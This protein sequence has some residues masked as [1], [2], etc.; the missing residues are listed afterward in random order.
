MSP[1]SFQNLVSAV[2]KGTGKAVAIR[3]RAELEPVG[4]ADT[5]VFPPTYTHGDKDEPCYAIN[6]RIVNGEERNVSVVLDSVPSQA[7]RASLAMEDDIHAP[8][9]Y[10]NGKLPLKDILPLVST[11]HEAIGKIYDLTAPHRVSDAIFRDSLYD[12]TLFR[13]S[14]VGRAITQA[15]SRDISA[16]F[17]HS[18][19][20]L[21]FGYWDSSGPL[22]ERGHKQERLYSSEISGLD[23]QFGVTTSSKI[24]P[25]G[26]K[27]LKKKEIYVHQN[28]DEVWTLSPEDARKG[29]GNKSETIGNPSNL[30]HGNIKPAI[31]DTTGGAYI[32][33]AIQTSTLSIQATQ[34]LRFGERNVE[35]EHAAHTV[36]IALGLVAMTYLYEAGYHLRSGCSLVSTGAPYF[37]MIEKDGK[38]KPFS[39]T[40][41]EATGLL[42]EAVQEAEKYGIG[43]DA[44]KDSIRMTMSPKLVELV[45]L[46]REEDSLPEDES[47][48]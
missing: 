29:K 21:L 45:Q 18:P 1:L 4:G 13:I 14:D 5:K 17:K 24:D 23:P 42:Q 38:T 31:N 11:E 9:L 40:A 47:R 33:K 37:E 46:S 3:F 8:Q 7:N 12:G 26:I 2:G 20:S 43:W 22:K 32:S 27:K 48:N 28:R 10:A 35:K 19:I 6:K 41:E 39:L 25:L 15:N 36:I 30:L 16:V 34:K 44:E